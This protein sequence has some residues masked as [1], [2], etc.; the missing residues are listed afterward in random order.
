M[1]EMH[2]HP[3]APLDWP[4]LANE[5]DRWHAAGRVATLWWRD[6]DAVAPSAALD[7]LLAIAGE[8]PVAF[9][10][11]PAA[12]AQELAA[13]L[14]EG[15]QAAVLQHGWRHV[16]HAGDGKKSEFPASRDADAVA[17]ELEAG[18]DRLASLFGDRALPVLAPP[19][20]RFDDS[21]LP[22]LA[23]AGLGAISRRGPR[24]APSPAAG[25]GEAD[26]HA[27]LV[28]WREGRGFVGAAAALAAILGHLACR[29]QGLVDAEEPTG[30]LTHHRI[31]DAPTAAFLHHLVDL[32]AAHPAARWLAAAEVF[33]TA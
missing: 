22:L 3:G 18:R 10:V 16:N 1:V 30:V 31:A 9:A 27:D 26:I 23:G 29:R 15:P 21:F 8:V 28:A 25:I 4:D 13:A 19:W 20:N 12:A 7:R 33:A 6:D 11:I 32:T 2:D 17:A 5:L 14:P 24:R